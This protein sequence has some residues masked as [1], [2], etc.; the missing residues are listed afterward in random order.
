[1]AAELDVD[2]ARVF[3]IVECWIICPILCAA[4]A[5]LI[6]VVT[7]RIVGRYQ[8]SAWAKRVLHGLV[9]ASACYASYSLGANNLGNAIGPIAT[10][11]VID[12]TLLSILGAGSIALGALTFAKGVTETVGKSITRFDVTGAF[13]AQ[14]SSAFG[15]HLFSMLGVPVS[16][17]Q[18][19][20]GGVLGVGLVHG[21]RTISTRKTAE[22]AIGWVATPTGAGLFAFSIYHLVS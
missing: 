5:A 11:E 2:F 14:A 18:A 19:I 4:L 6:Y 8:H 1:M 22:I 15:L 21:I 10:L 3:T 16:T 7:R 20:V 13:A 9:I 17:S 12:L